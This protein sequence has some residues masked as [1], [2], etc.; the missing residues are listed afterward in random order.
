MISVVMSVEI[1]KIR[2][3]VAELNQSIR[4]EYEF[5]FKTTVVNVYC[6]EATDEEFANACE[7]LLARL[8]TL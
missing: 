8:V 2:L 6:I 1:S 7:L 5:D 4:S 3:W